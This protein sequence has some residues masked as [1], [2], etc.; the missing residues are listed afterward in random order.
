MYGNSPDVP[1]TALAPSTLISFDA[2]ARLRTRL[3]GLF[4]RLRVP[5]RRLLVELR[6][7]YG[8]PWD[9]SRIP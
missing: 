7:V 9:D 5:E 8:K 1:R 3:H 6:E 4:V 2:A